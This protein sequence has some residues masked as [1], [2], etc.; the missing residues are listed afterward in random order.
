MT[1][2]ILDKDYQRIDNI[3][4]NDKTHIFYNSAYLNSTNNQELF[5]SDMNNRIHI[6]EDNQPK[7]SNPRYLFVSLYVEKDK[8]IKFHIYDNTLEQYRWIFNNQH[9]LNFKYD[10]LYMRKKN[11]K[12]L[13]SKRP[14]KWEIIDNHIRNI[15]ENVYITCD[16]EYNIEFTTNKNKAIKFYFDNG[17]IHYI[18]PI[19]N[20]QFEYNNIIQKLDIN[21]IKLLNNLHKN[22]NI[23]ILLAGGIGSRFSNEISKQLFKLNT[24]P[25]LTYSLE[26][27]LN[28]LDKIIIVTNSKCIKDIKKIVRMTGHMKRINIVNNDINCRLESIN[29]GLDFIKRKF[30]IYTKNV[31]IHDSARP[32]ITEKHILDLLKSNR[33]FMYSQYCLKLTNGLL[34]KNSIIPNR[35][36]YL[37]LCTPVCINFDLCYFIFKHYIIEQYRITWEIIPILNLLNIEYNLIFGNYEEL[38]KITTIH[39]I[40]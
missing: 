15:K 31:L 3:L 14:S 8:H 35:D 6:H 16:L 19:I 34:E 17:S 29:K 39:D 24:K 1:I 37:E 21:N 11:N 20:V 2:K 30:N 33:M 25:I 38:K 4:Y 13:L 18:K 22:L 36:D 9:I 10:G 32:F 7:L 28:T 40:N 26:I 5:K 12:L 27:M 23:G